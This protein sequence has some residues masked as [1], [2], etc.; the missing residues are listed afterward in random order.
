MDIC[1]GGAKG[2]HEASGGCSLIADDLVTCQPGHDD[3]T[4]NRS[5]DSLVTERPL[6]EYNRDIP[7]VVAKEV[8][9]EEVQ[10]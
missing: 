9:R 10:G 7:E 6:L 1:R 5:S 2:S 8:P 3:M 4:I